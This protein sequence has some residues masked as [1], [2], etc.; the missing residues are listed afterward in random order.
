MISKEEEIEGLK[1]EENL[2][3]S[4]VQANAASLDIKKAK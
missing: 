2:Q 1:T 4:I 3:I